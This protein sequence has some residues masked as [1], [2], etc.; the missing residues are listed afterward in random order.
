[1]KYSGRVASCGSKTG[2]HISPQYVL[3]YIR[4]YMP[5][6]TDV[7]WLTVCLL[8][9][10]HTVSKATRNFHVLIQVAGMCL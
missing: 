1:M 8:C 2:H 6:G 7:L 9:R 5:V 3:E 10:F 4:I